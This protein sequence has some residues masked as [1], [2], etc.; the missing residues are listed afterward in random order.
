MGITADYKKQIVDLTKGLKEENI[1]ELVDFA[2]FLREKQE[3]FSYSKV[4][5]SAAYVR[6]LRTKDPRKAGS[7]KK[8]IQELIAWQKS[9]S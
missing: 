7:E 1:R 2:Q 3:R 9:E 8:Y 5:D 6:A 4:T